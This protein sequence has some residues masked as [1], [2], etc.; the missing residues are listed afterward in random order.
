[1]VQK[2]RHEMIAHL[3]SVH[4]KCDWSWPQRENS[5]GLIIW[6]ANR[7]NRGTPSSGITFTQQFGCSRLW[8]I[9][10]PMREVSLVASTQYFCPL[11]NGIKRKEDRP[12]DR[13]R[14]EKTSNNKLRVRMQLFKSRDQI[15]KRRTSSSNNLNTNHSVQT[16]TMR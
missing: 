7:T 11:E 6:R 2:H 16:Q 12:H 1:M 5:P 15:Q 3:Y 4:F 8:L 14:S 9:S 13:R 10:R